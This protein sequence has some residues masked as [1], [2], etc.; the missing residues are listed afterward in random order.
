[1][2]EKHCPTPWLG[3]NAA[4]LKSLQFFKTKGSA[5]PVYD[6]V[7]SIIV[8]QEIAEKCRHVILGNVILMSQRAFQAKQGNAT[9]SNCYVLN[10]MVGVLFG[11]KGKVQNWHL[12][13]ANLR[14]CFYWEWTIFAERCSHST[15]LVSEYS[16]MQ[17]FSFG[18]TEF[19]DIE[20]SRLFSTISDRRKKRDRFRRKETY[21][22]QEQIYLVERKN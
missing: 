15:V 4:T 21:D 7:R 20:N 3:R 13:T 11:L 14:F 12:I 18:G 22:K 17:A 10:S 6:D 19:E 2:V 1:M 5:W 9:W 16:V 8:G